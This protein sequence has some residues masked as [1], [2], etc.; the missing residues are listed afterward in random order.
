MSLM[1]L[2]AVGIYLEVDASMPGELE[3]QA[4]SF[5]PYL[6]S[7]AHLVALDHDCNPCF[8]NLRF[9]DLPK[10]LCIDLT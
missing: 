1:F 9:Q 2:D 4:A 10:Q 3:G 6:A 5:D 7:A 8:R